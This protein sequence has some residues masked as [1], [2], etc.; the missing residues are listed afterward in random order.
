LLRFEADGIRLDT[1]PLVD[2]E[3][4]RDWSRQRETTLPGMS[5]VG[6]AWSE[7]PWQLCFFQGG[8]TGWDGIDPGVDSVFDFPLHAAIVQVF[9][10]RAPA[11]RL[12]TVFSRDGLYPRADRLVTFL[13]NHDTPRLAASAGVSPARYRAA[14]AF[15]LTT[16]GIPQMT[17]GDE[18]GLPGRGMDDRR[19]F[20]GGFPGD[21][22][23]AFLAEGRTAEEQATFETWKSLIRLRRSSVALRRGRQIDLAAVEKTYAFLREASDERL[24]VVLNVGTNPATV[25]IPIDR[26][27][28]ASRFETVYGSAQSRLES[29]GLIVDLAGESASVIRA[30]R[31]TER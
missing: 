29:A 17:W 22:R 31:A 7:D 8:R 6:E 20:P 18:I 24:I 14:V 15:L 1:Y 4:W 26:I 9:S 19:D 10:G 11:T 5:V 23:N 28:G 25:R 3:F 12:S 16:R 30:T 13:D 27:N 2:R 21:S